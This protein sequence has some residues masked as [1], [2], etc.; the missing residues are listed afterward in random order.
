MSHTASA[1]SDYYSD[2]TT[3]NNYLPLQQHE[4]LCSPTAL[5]AKSY[6]QGGHPSGL[7]VRLIE[8]YMN[9]HKMR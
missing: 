7:F 5:L 9:K 2:I 4:P 8:L 3:V 6:N 1:S